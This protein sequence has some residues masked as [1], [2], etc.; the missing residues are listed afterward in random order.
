MDVN[1]YGAW[2]MIKA[3]LPF[4]REKNSGSIINISSFASF[5]PIPFHA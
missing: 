3:T 5:T 1:F 2:H 4:M